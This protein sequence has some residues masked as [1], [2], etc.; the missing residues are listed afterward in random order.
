VAKREFS[1]SHSARYASE[2][3]D[4][5][6]LATMNFVECGL[7]STEIQAAIQAY[8]VMRAAQINAE[9]VTY[10]GKLNREADDYQN[11]ANR[12]DKRIR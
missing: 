8:G 6:A 1:I 9:T 2:L 4:E 10:E 5:L 7:T 11:R 12:N 3:A